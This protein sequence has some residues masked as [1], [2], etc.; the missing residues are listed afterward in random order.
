[1]NMIK[2]VLL[3]AIYFGVGIFILNAGIRYLSKTLLNIGENHIK[4]VL[5][6]YTKNTV[7]SFF[8]GFFLSLLLQGS[9]PVMLCSISLINTGMMSFYNSLGIIY[10]ANL[11]T[12]FSAILL[13]YNPEYMK[14]VILVAGLLMKGFIRKDKLAYIGDVLISIGLIFTGISV[15]KLSM[16]IFHDQLMNSRLFTKYGEHV[17]ANF[18]LSTFVT[19]VTH[20]SAAVTAVTI[21]MFKQGIIGK[22]AVTAIILGSNLGT[23][24]TAQIASFNTGSEAVKMAWA[25]TLYNLIGSLAG[26]FLL[27]PL[28]DLIDLMLTWFQWNTDL[29]P[30]LCHIMINL[31]SALI[32]I[33][34]TKPYYWLIN[35]IVVEDK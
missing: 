23:C 5:L 16:P 8:S 10:G 27:T 18:G 13:T 15:L 32:F 1:M 24:I 4:P 11:G 6:K 9:T 14:Y 30:A 34:L 33:P 12:T 25:H 29:F 21:L 35:K 7:T 17:L 20:S 19:A 2:V 3:I 22:T 26:L 31:I 28:T